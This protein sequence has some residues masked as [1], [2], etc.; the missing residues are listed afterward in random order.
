MQLPDTLRW[1]YTGISALLPG[2][3][4]AAQAFGEEVEAHSRAG[5]GPEIDATAVY[6]PRVHQVAQQRSWKNAFPHCS[7][8]ASKLSAHLAGL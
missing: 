1:Q 5:E 4:A 7:G 6:A 2:Q 3:T 8:T